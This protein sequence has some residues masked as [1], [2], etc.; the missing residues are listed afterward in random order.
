MAEGKM[1]IFSNPA[2]P[3]QEAEY[4]R[5]YNETHLKEVTAADT[6]TGATRYRFAAEQIP[7]QDVGPWR[8]MAMYH[9]VEPGPAI[10]DMLAN[11]AGFTPSD[12]AAP[13][14]ITT[15][16]VYEKIFEKRKD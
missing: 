1:V 12:A 9:L 5:W 16:V 10:A 2:S 7:G 4:N 3:E 8:Y 13:G 14:A 15:A 6:M 11:A